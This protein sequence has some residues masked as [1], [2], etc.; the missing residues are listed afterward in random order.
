MSQFEEKGWVRLPKAFDPSGMAEALWHALRA[1]GMR[2]DDPMTWKQSGGQA[3]ADKWLTKFGKSGVF[4]GV[5]NHE[6]DAALDQLLGDGWIEQSGRWGSPLVTFPTE[7]GWD[8]PTGGWHLD[9][10]PANPLSAVRMFAY[11]SEVREHGGGTLI[12]EGSHRLATAY[13][14]LHSRVVR[15]RLSELHPWFRELWQPVDVERRLPVLMDEG[16]HVRSVR[17]RVVELT[18]SPGD[19]VLWHPSL[20]HVGA[21]NASS[22]PRLML[23][24][25]VLRRA[26]SS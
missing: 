26:D 18:G 23:T 9:M 12:V 15:N 3:L 5:A 7:G 24:H 10:P 21:P 20:F 2:P 6:V 1:H 14:G 4:A 17:V 25:T 19:V 16:A 8:V 13:P 11:L 22:Q